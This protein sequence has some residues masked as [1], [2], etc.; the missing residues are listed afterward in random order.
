MNCGRSII[1]TIIARGYHY[2]VAQNILRERAM[3]K[4]QRERKQVMQNAMELGFK[5]KIDGFKEKMKG[6]IVLPNEP[7]YDEIRKIWNAMIDRYPAR[8]EERRVGKE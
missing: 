8:S 6:R 2:C 7:D 4:N 1:E 5:Q 3:T